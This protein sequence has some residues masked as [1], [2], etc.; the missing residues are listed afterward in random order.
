M[1]LYK[2]IFGDDSSRYYYKYNLCYSCR[3]EKK[4]DEKQPYIYKIKGIGKLHNR[5]ICNNCLQKKLS[6]SINK[7]NDSNDSYYS[8]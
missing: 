7:S 4:V 3:L 2:W 8:D 1:T 6:K 5:F